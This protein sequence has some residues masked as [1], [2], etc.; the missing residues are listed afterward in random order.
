[1]N[2]NEIYNALKKMRELSKAN[3]PF[4][5]TYV[6]C[7]QTNQSSKGLKTV[8]KAALRTGY[9][10]EHSAKHNSLIGYVDLQTGKNGWF[11][12]PLLMS[13]NKIDLP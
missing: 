2:L 11:Y 12:L 8:K 3:V 4:E 9:S 10:Q 6:S 5:F 7:N 1:M 13:L